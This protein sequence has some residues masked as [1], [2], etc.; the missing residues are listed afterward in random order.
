ME[1]LPDRVQIC[2]SYNDHIS[3]VVANSRAVFGENVSF[4]QVVDDL[5]NGCCGCQLF[6]PW[7]KQDVA[8]IPNCPA[9]FN[10]VFTHDP[11]VVGNKDLIDVLS[12]G[13]NHIP[14]APPDF[15][16]VLRQLIEIALLYT[17]EFLIPRLYMAGAAPP[18][19]LFCVDSHARQWCSERLNVIKGYAVIRRL[20]K[21]DVL[22]SVDLLNALKSA[23]QYLL[24]TE[25]DKSPNTAFF[26]S[27][28]K[29]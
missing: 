5:S 19:L 4:D 7:Y 9:A 21:C 12:K 6:S 25:I 8:F 13:L 15:S 2:W 23:Q 22:K 18:N 20:P 14:L 26:C 29:K 10:H 11:S 28:S 16:D 17:S 3:T 24:I 27:V 1:F